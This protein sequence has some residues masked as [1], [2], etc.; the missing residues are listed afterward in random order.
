MTDIIHADHDALGEHLVY[1]EAVEYADRPMTT[2]DTGELLLTASLDMPTRFSVEQVELIRAR[3]EALATERNTLRAEVGRLT[4]VAVW[5]AEQAA[6]LEGNSVL[7]WIDAAEDAVANP[8]APAPFRPRTCGTHAHADDLIDGDTHR[9]PR[10]GAMR[11]EGYMSADDLLSG[12]EQLVQEGRA[13][14][15]H[16]RKALLFLTT[17]ADT[18]AA[19]TEVAR[20]ASKA[21]IIQGPTALFSNSRRSNYAGLRRALAHPAVQAVLTEE[22][23]GDGHTD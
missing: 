6:L 11:E 20:A 2:I 15:N 14:V 1:R 9:L 19:L 13:S 18:I 7:D 3:I 10:G 16:Y 4:A 22:G 8:V 21:D 17:Q 5:L 12:I 23:E